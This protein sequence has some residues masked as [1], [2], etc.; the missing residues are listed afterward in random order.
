MFEFEVLKANLKFRLNFIL[1]FKSLNL[2]F[3]R[4]DSYKVD[5]E[6]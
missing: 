3:E 2:W 6:V 1:M 5:F 4:I